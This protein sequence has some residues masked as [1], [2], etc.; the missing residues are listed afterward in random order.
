M[1]ELSIEEKAKAYDEALKAAIAA[2]KDEDRHLK[3]TLERIFP[4]LKDSKDERIRN[5]IINFIEE[6]GNPIHCEWQKDWIAWLEKQG[7]HVEINPTEFDTRLQA[8]I[9]K[10]E[11][12]P[13]EELVGSL[14]FWLNVVQNDGTYKADEKQ[15]KQN[16]C[17]TCSSPRLNCQNFPCEKKKNF[18]FSN[19]VEPKFKVG[20]FI[21]NDYGM[22]MRITGIKNDKYEFIFEDKLQ[23][24]PI[25]S[26]DR[27][28]HLWTV[29]DAKDGDVLAFDNETMVIFKDLYNATTFHS[30]CHIEDGVFTASEKDVPDWWEGKGFQPATKEQRDTLMKAMTDAG[31]TFNFEKKELKKL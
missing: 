27:N 19:K 6:Y 16:P 9:G 31:Y 24:W 14:S 4:E 25:V 20:D 30:C 7:E 23:S 1:K 15:D 18:D 13:K 22:V 3:A 11:T 26:T 5:Q 28:C 21:V 29:Q 2:H 8:L 17:E 10:F 12:L